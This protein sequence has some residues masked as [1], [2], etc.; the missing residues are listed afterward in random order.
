MSSCMS[1]RR[2]NHIINIL[3]VLYG[4]KNTWTWKIRLDG[5]VQSHS[6]DAT[7]VSSRLKSIF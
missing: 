1:L 3:V 6:S 4:V 5:V 7:T 2:E